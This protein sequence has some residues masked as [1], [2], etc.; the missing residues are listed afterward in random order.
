MKIPASLQAEHQ[1]VVAAQSDWDGSGMISFEELDIS[2]QS[3]GKCSSGNVE[4][5][6]G[7]VQCQQEG[8]F[9]LFII[10]YHESELLWAQLKF[11]FTNSVSFIS[12]LSLLILYQ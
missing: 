2:V 7:S 5:P 11:S 10:L 4:D 12:I 6:G 8:K 1:S 9:V 3:P